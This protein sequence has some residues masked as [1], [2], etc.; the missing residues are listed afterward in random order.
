MTITFPVND[1]RPDQAFLDGT[2]TIEA[3]NVTT[4]ARG[5]GP[6]P[7]WA[8]VT[9]SAPLTA[10][11]Q[12][13]FFARKSDN[14][15]VMF[16]GDATKL[17][18]LTGAT[19][20]N[21]SRVTGGPYNC[22]VDGRWSFVQFGNNVL[23]FN[24]SDVPQQINIDSGANFGPLTG[25]PQAHYAAIVGDFV[26]TGNQDPTSRSL[27]Q[28]SAINDCTSWTASQQT[29]AD[30]QLLPDGGMVQAIFGYNYTA[31]ILQEFSIKTGT[32][33]GPALIFRFATIA[34]DLGCM[35]P[36]SAAAYGDYCFFYSQNGLYMLQAAA[37]L[38]PIGEQRVNNWLKAN[39]NQ[40]FLT[41]C[42]AGIDPVKSFY[43]FGFPDQSSGGLINHFL[44]YNYALDKFSHAQAGN[45]EWVQSTMT[46]SSW[47]IEQLAT[48]Y[49][50]IENVPFPFDSTVWSGTGAP[51]LGGFDANHTLGFYN[52]PP[53][54]ATVTA[55][56][57]NL[58][59]GK[60]AFV[61][62]V[63]PL[64]EGSSPPAISVTL[65]TRNRQTD[66]I[67]YGV[68][69]PMDQF[70]YCRFRSKGRYHSAKIQL[71]AGGSWDYVLGLTDPLF[72]P[73]GTR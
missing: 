20:I 52:G 64:V 34:K 59:D 6:L 37:Q 58:I 5:Y 62:G 38:T 13:T 55:G 14:T 63:R 53:L 42:C 12:G 3:L 16:A 40:S 73:F 30:S 21:V 67:S 28:W 7:S 61:R 29:Q 39:V 56:E 70:G 72:V 46:Q 19:W 68:T 65:G 11:A 51:V 23:A 9:P 50:T 1:W 41:R 36:G 45:F 22:P 26:M 33:E 17:Y 48:T 31:I 15:G 60:K 57:L 32:Y 10:R 18:Q 2:G 8:S 71:A 25:A 35:V 43:V 27:V 4:K 44:L 49:G 54:A 47:T 66:P 69:V 24:G